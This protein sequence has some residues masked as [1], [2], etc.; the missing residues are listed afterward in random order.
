MKSYNVV[1]AII[2]Y[3]NKILCTQRGVGK[4]KYISYKYEFPGGKVENGETKEQALLREIQEE[5]NLKICIKKHFTTVE[6][7]YPDFFIHMD[8]FICESDTDQIDLKEHIDC[9]WLE[10]KELKLLDWAE[11]DIP[12]IRKLELD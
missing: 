6:H 12:I 7:M 8:A 10:K 3:D 9:K 11:A 1:A 4:Y 5:L 2:L